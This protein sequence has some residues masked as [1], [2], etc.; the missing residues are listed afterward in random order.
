VDEAVDP[1]SKSGVTKKRKAKSEKPKVA[2]SDDG[3]LPTA[4]FLL[5]AHRRSRFFYGI[6]QYAESIELRAFSRKTRHS[7][8]SR[9]PRTGLS[10][11]V[12][13]AVVPGLKSGVTKKRKAKGRR[14][15]AGSGTF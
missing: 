11:T 7:G 8:E 9:N 12:D 15:K 10:Y 5:F 1:G 6:K 2:P 13:K 14:R 3:R 4:H